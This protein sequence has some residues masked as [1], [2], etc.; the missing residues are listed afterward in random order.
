MSKFGIFTFYNVPNYG[1][2]LQAY[3]LQTVIES[4]GYQ[5]EFIRFYE[6]SDN[7]K[8]A[9]GIKD[10]YR[11]LKGNGFN[12]TTYMLAR[13]IVRFKNAKF[14]EFCE[15]YMN[16]S[17]D[18]F[19]SINELTAKQHMY[20]GFVC[21]SDMVWSNLGQNMDAFFLT[22][23]EECKRISYAPSITGR[24]D[25]NAEEKAFYKNSINHMPFLSCREAYGV[26]YIKNLTGRDAKL[27]L[28]PTLLLTKKQ[29]M[30]LLHLKEQRSSKPYILCYIFGELSKK[31]A[32]KIRKFHKECS[33]DI[34]YIPMSGCLMREELEH[35]YD[36]VYGPKEFVEL[37]LNADFVLTNSYHGL[38][39]SIIMQK[40][41]Y[42][43]HRGQKSEWAVHEERMSNILKLIHQE[44]RFIQAEQ[45]EVNSE[46]GMDY[47]DIN[48]IIERERKLSLAYLKNALDTVSKY[49]DSPIPEKTILHNIGELDK[50]SCTGCSVCEHLCPTHCITMKE[51]AEGFS[52]P[53]VKESECVGCHKCVEGCQAVSYQET[54]YPKES[55]CGYGLIEEVAYSASGGAFIT[56]AKWMI[57]SKDGIVFGAAMDNKTNICHHIMADKIAVLRRMQNSKYVQSDISDAL[58]KCKE[59]LET[60]KNVLFSGTPCQIAALNKFLGKT[61]KNLYTIDIIC[62][63]VPSPGFF[64]QYLQKQIGKNIESYTFRHKLDK[65]QKRSAFEAVIVKNGKRKIIPGVEDIYYKAFIT[66]SSYRESCYSCKYADKQRVGD[67]TIGDCDSW[68]RYQEF[69]ATEI[70]SSIIINT[71]QGKELWDAVHNKFKYVNMDY[72]EEC[73]AN[74]QLCRPTVRPSIRDKIYS[75]LKNMDWRKIQRKYGTNRI[76]YIFKKCILYVIRR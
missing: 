9:L 42:L 62:H 52:E 66:G 10:Y 63:G 72:E 39:F 12:F 23:T 74:H 33:M 50:N 44:G 16:T 34:R 18:A 58:V 4:M 73:I 11:I 48:F 40:P 68:R 37:F 54:F 51:N 17:K 59:C 13:S 65:E 24:E 27:V 28:D 5:S 49:P 56:I 45:L 47:A 15:R 20:T 69:K 32:S 1:A 8:K 67:I 61:Y 21:G 22:F 53:V 30:E 71:T 70:T 36:A 38:L 76:K 25:E 46:M 19:Y 64:K 26:K 31:S 75:D 2:A 29:W 7:D 43:F 55:F 57:E 60:E 14:D 41:F 3:A 6:N 35:G